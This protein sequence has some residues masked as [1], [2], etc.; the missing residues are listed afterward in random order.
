MDYLLSKLCFSG[1]NQNSIFRLYVQLH[2]FLN[3]K[4]RPGLISCPIMAG[5]KGACLSPGSS[6]AVI[7]AHNHLLLQ[8]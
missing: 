8:F 1:I 3:F 2:Y 7:K 6:G 4:F 5:N